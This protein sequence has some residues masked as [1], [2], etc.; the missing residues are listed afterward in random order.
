MQLPSKNSGVQNLFCNYLSQE[1]IE[2]TR[3]LAKNGVFVLKPTVE[4]QQSLD[5]IQIQMAREWK[6][7][8]GEIGVKVLEEMNIN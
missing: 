2:K 5:E 7:I 4:F 1:T 6:E 8:A 3:T